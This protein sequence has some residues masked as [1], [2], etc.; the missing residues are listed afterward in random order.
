VF[1]EFYRGAFRRKIYHG[2]EELQADLN[3]WLREYNE[4]RSHQGRW[5]YGKT[6]LQTFVDSIALAEEKIL[7]QLELAPAAVQGGRS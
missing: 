1:N 4:R 6:P 2:L 3:D 7:S 5:C